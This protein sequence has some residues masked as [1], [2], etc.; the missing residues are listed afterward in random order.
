MFQKF[1][2]WKTTVYVIDDFLIDEDIITQL[3]EESFID[4][5]IQGQ[6]EYGFTYAQKHL[7]EKVKQVAITYCAE[8]E[9][10]FNSL[11]LNDV[12]KGC[13]YK[14]D[15]KM[16]HNHLY[17]PHHDMVEQ[18]FV[19]AIYYVDSAY[20]DDKWIGGELAIYK[21]LTFADYPNNTINILPK[22]NRLI[23]FPGFLH[24]RVKPYFGDTPRTS[25]L[26]G[27]RVNESTNREPLWI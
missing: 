21:H 19:T 13:L 18:G 23:V 4:T 12:Q 24:H 11:A 20:T 7:F 17:E 25:L 15:E 2:L 16:V 27:W 9:I 8:N 5:T 1:E 14:Y 26:F 22:A 10:D 3:K 6:N